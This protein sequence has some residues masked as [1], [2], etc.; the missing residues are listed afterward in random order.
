M[1]AIDNDVLLEVELFERPV[2]EFFHGNKMPTG[3][4][5]RIRF[6]GLAHIQKAQC[7]AGLFGG[8]L[9][10]AVKIVNG[11]FLFH[12]RFRIHLGMEGRLVQEIESSRRMPMVQTG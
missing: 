4:G 3:N 7:L 8:K 1:M 2:G 6:P 10:E 12:T 11:D 5:R 9:A